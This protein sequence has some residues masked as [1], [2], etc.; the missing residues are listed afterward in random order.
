MRARG[1]RVDLSLP[2]RSGRGER[3]GP[4]GGA[5]R[6]G[7]RAGMCP[8][9]PLREHPSRGGRLGRRLRPAGAAA[10]SRGS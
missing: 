4:H 5:E 6:V 10:Q 1:S 9:L 3:L 8:R 2:C 7:L